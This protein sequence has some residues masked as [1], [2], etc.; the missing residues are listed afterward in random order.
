MATKLIR[1]SGLVLILAGLLVA[2]PV[3]FHPSD[4]D[5]SS[6]L[7]TPW[8]PIHA[9]FMLGAILALFGLVGLYLR[10]VDQRAWLRL[11]GFVLAFIGH[12]LFVGALLFEA[13][14]LPELAANTGASALLD[15]TG[16]L[17]GGPLG[18]VLLIAGVSFALGSLLFGL[19]LLRT[20]FAGRWAGALVLV[21]GPL[22]AFWPPLPQLVGTLGGLMLGLG[23]SWLGYT[24]FQ[25]VRKGALQ[26]QAGL[27]AA[28]R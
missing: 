24:V 2:G 4:T 16:P 25:P 9:L 1:W 17:F 23:Y 26:P 7:T 12:A 18:I 21:G 14:I 28:K 20:P 19:A 6:P 15:E 5:P 13:F 8:V 22:L 27:S 10:D 3:L 11:S